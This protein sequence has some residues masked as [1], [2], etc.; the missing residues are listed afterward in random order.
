LVTFSSSGLG[1]FSC[2]SGPISGSDFP[3]G[4]RSGSGYLL[5]IKDQ[6]KCK[7]N[8]K[9]KTKHVYVINYDIFVYLWQ[10]SKDHDRDPHPDLDPAKWCGSDWIRIR[11]TDFFLNVYVEKRQCFHVGTY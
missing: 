2:R 8:F 10:N 7:I 3:F 9:R 5:L 11:N 1:L 4:S 6:R